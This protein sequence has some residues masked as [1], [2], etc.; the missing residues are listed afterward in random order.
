MAWAAEPRLPELRFEAPE[1]M[2]PLVERLA[3]YD[4]AR[5][6][7]VMKLVGLEDGGLPIR[8][9]LAP[10][11]SPAARVAPSWGVGYAVGNAGLVVLL[12]SRVPGYPDRDLESVLMHELAHVLIARAARRR[13]VPR[14]LNEGLAIAAAREHGLGDQARLALATLRQD[15]LALGTLD[16][17]FQA[18]GPTASRAYALAA[19]F[20]RDLLDRH[21]DTVVALILDR[22][23]EDVPFEV[24]FRDITG[25]G[26]RRA[27]ARFWRDISFWNKWVP[28]LTSSAVLWIVVTLLALVAIRRRRVRDAEMRALWE[29]EEREEEQRLEAIVWSD[30]PPRDELVN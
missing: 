24:A 6:R 29:E 22:L 27:E 12:P 11:G 19:T 30:E 9:V 7:Y 15:E 8:V 20:V 14:W 28:F 17:K 2:A 1:A 13:P 23:G 16:S 10:E 3:A 21:G 26:L 4:E 5:L 25:L 18:G